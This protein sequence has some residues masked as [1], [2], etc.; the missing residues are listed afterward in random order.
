MRHHY[1][2]IGFGGGKQACMG[3]HFAGRQ[4]KSIWTLL[5]DHFDFYLDTESPRP[6]YDNWVTG[7]KTD[8]LLPV[9]TTCTSTSWTAALRSATM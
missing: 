4:Q 7:P 9:E 1:A 3:K 6:N 5:L 2:L 8:R